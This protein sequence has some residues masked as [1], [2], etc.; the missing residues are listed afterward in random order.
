V[1]PAFTVTEDPVLEPLI[2]PFP[3]TD[4]L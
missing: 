4:Q 3:L 1:P 2:V